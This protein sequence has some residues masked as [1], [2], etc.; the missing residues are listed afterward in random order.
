MITVQAALQRGQSTLFYAEVDTPLLDATV[1]LGE[2]LG[3][4]LEVNAPPGLQQV[5]ASNR[6]GPNRWL[7]QPGAATRP[8]WLGGPW[9]DRLGTIEE[10]ADLAP[11]VPQQLR[12]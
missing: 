2:A 11:F 1:L 5:Y 6:W 8:L 7:V 3:L 4:V 9:D 10:H 12:G